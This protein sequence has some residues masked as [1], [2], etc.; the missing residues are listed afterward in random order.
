MSRRE[1][2]SRHIRDAER[3]IWWMIRVLGR[4]MAAGLL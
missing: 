4:P 2:A 1:I 3:H